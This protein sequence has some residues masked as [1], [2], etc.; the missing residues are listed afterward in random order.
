MLIELRPVGDDEDARVRNTLDDPLGQPDH[1]QALA[2]ALG[3]PDD[4][5]LASLRVLLRGAHTEV[6]VVPAELLH[7]GV[8][9]DEIVDQLQEARLATELDKR[10]VQRVLDGARF[11]PREV[12]LLRRLDRA[13]A[14]ALGVVAG[15]HPLHR[16]EE[17]LDE[18]LL[19]V[20]EVLADALGHRD[21]GTLEL[22][23]AERDAV[24]VE[25]HVRALGVGLGGGAR[26]R[27]FLGDGEVVLLRALPVDEPDG[28]HVLAD[29]GLHLHPVAQQVVHSTVAVI[30][31][32]ARIARRLVEE[33]HRPRHERLVVAL[34]L[35]QERPQQRLLDVAVALAV[36]PVSQVGVA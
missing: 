12:V 29:L 26:H 23:H 21:R 31:A 11:L 14:Q 8:E 6:L 2:R 17:V 22:Q 13:V 16:R 5:A 10:A 25:H 20:V 32:L 30:E 1:D 15:H 27:H 33:V 18:D 34:L 9:H 7:P 28:L 36:G 3:V 24:D 4:P 35:A 19:L